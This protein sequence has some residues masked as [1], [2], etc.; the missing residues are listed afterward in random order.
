MPRKLCS[1]GYDDSLDHVHT[2]F[3]ADIAIQVNS[4]PLQHAAR[5][6]GSLSD[7]D[8]IWEALREY[9]DRIGSTGN[10]LNEG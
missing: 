9:K 3:L 7:G 4:F 10:K 1:N 6:L 8:K 2:K 5:D